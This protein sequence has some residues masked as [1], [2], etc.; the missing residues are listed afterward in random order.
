MQAIQVQGLTRLYRNGRGVRNVNLSVEPGSIFG[1]LG[2]NGAGKTTLIRTVLGYMKP[3]AG[4]ASVLGIDAIARSREVRRKVGYLPSDPALYDFL[5]GRENIEFAL[6]VRGVKGRARVSELSDRLEID[7]GRRLKTLSRGNKQKVAIV[8]ALAHDPEL[9]ILDEPTSGLDPLVQET[10]LQLIRE[11]QRRGKT[12]FMSSHIMSEVEAVC[13][14]V[15]IIR[16]GEIV[17]VD[18]VDRMKK[19]RVKYVEVEFAGEVPDL[20]A[21]AGVD[22]WRVE[23]QKATF[24]MAGNLDTLV[25]ELGKRSLVDLTLSDPPLEEVFRRFYESGGGG[26]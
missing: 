23:G 2:P 13:S 12:V 7:L 22:G 8:A 25:A 3:Q 18:T 6:L 21:M 24:T 17:A 4:R 10:F 15:G 19:Q 26:R 14:Q 5:T 1:F 20:S 16:D 9:L 11:E